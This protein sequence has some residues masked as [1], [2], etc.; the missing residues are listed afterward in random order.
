MIDSIMFIGLFRSCYDG[1][2]DFRHCSITETLCD[3]TTHLVVVVVVGL[4]LILSAYEF[5]NG[6]PCSQAQDSDDDD[7]LCIVLH[8]RTTLPSCA[9]KQGTRGLISPNGVMT[10]NINKFAI[11]YT[12][13]KQTYRETCSMHQ[14]LKLGAVC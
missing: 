2:N 6:L 14:Q 4:I 9:C 7:V 3:I 1:R 10:I 12:A 11:R 8:E 5:R 13:R